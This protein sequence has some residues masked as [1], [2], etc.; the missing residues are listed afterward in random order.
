MSERIDYDN[1][2]VRVSADTRPYRECAQYVTCRSF[3]T[4]MVP[5]LKRGFDIGTPT[6]E[7]APQLISFWSDVCKASSYQLLYPEQTLILRDFSAPILFISTVAV[8]S[9]D[10]IPCSVP[11]HI[12]SSTVQ[13][14]YADASSAARLLTRFASYLSQHRFDLMTLENIEKKE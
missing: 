6:V 10:P 4:H 11:Q 14:Q 8:K 2:V 7:P 13:Q 5:A 1:L 9:I 12:L 3:V